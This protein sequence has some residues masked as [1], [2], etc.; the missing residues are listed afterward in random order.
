MF[1]PGDLVVYQMPRTGRVKGQVT[2]IVADPA[3]HQLIIVRVTSRDNPY[4]AH[5]SELSFSYCDPDLKK[6][7]RYAPTIR[8]EAPPSEAD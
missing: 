2:D 1:T 8:R 3:R 5:G 4:Y 7:K 6:R